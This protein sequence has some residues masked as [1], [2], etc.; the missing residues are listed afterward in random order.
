MPTELDNHLRA[1]T[2]GRISRRELLKRATVL[3]V[4]MND[5]KATGSGY[6]YR[7]YYGDDKPRKGLR[8]L[9]PSKG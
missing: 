3:G 2:E 6:Y 1:F 5:A 7:A 9:L 8:K 4:V